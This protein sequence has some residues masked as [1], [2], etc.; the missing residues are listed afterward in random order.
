M[1]PIRT[2]QTLDETTLRMLAELLRAE[3]GDV[4]ATGSARPPQRTEL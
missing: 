2:G 3:L 1:I 4:L